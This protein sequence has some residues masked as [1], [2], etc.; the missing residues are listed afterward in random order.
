MC[1][2]VCVCV[3]E[4]FPFVVAAMA[5]KSEL[6]EGITDKHEIKSGLLVI[7]FHIVNLFLP[8]CK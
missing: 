5:F 3:K 4:Y 2:C 8:V 1:V 7:V 6:I